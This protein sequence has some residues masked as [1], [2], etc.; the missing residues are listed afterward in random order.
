MLSPVEGSLVGLDIRQGKGG[1]KA[2]QFWNSVPVGFPEVP[3]VKTLDD[4]ADKFVIELNGKE[5]KR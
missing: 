5:Q 2:L 3:R 4:P 1:K